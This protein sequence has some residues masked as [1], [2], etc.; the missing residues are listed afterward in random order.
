MKRRAFL[1]GAI[2]TAITPGAARAQGKS[3]ARVLK[4]VPQAD[5]TVVDP[6]VTT[7]NITRYHA[8]MIWDQLYGL[9]SDLRPHPQMVE[10]H[11]VEDDGK[12]WTFRLREGLR[13]HDG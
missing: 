7:A 8:F 5:L 13:F 1:K 9:D 3:A 2:A 11:T 4:W 10:G 6:V 12:R